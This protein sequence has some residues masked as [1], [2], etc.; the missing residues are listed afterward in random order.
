[1]QHTYCN[2]PGGRLKY[3]SDVHVLAQL[4]CTGV[5]D[6]TGKPRMWLERQLQ[7]SWIGAAMLSMFVLASQVAVCSSVL[8]CVAAWCSVVQCVAVCCSELQ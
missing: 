7:Y 3:C 4:D 8:Q 2:T 1:V 5:D 6:F